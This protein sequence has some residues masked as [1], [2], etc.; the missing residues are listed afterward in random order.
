MFIE[1]EVVQA[2]SLKKLMILRQYFQDEEASAVIRALL[3][4]VE[5]VHLKNFVHR[6]LKPDNI[7][8]GSFDDV[9]TL[10]LA[11]FGL[12]AS[13]RMNTYYSLSEKMGTV[14]YMA[15]EQTNHSTYGKVS[16]ISNSAENRHV[17]LWHNHVHA[18]PR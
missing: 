6:D 12:S 17:G 13:Y 7:L 8:I 1:M 5:H 16:I 3:G 10:K 2:G 9:S 14:L 15:P 11:D 4:A 18:N